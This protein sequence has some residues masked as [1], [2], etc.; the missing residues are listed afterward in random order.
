MF[1]WCREV[2]LQFCRLE[3]FSHFLQQLYVPRIGMPPKD[4]QR[5]VKDVQGSPQADDD[6]PDDW[7]VAGDVVLRCCTMCAKRQ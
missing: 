2:L 4:A 5:D 3:L 6:E 7:W 1:E